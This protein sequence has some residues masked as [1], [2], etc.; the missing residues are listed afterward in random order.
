MNPF[1]MSDNPYFSMFPLFY[2]IKTWSGCYLEI[3]YCQK[4]KIGQTK[5]LDDITDVQCDLLQVRSLYVDQWRSR[6]GPQSESGADS[7]EAERELTS[8]DAAVSGVRAR[9][10]LASLLVNKL[11][12]ERYCNGY[13]APRSLFCERHNRKVFC[14]TA[15]A[16]CW[17][18]FFS[19]PFFPHISQCHI[20]KPINDILSPRFKGE[21]S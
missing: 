1:W 20:A 4:N 17:I 19:L 9:R 10:R 3:S 7:P 18:I 8:G 15:K 11:K 16:I 21:N 13:H 6:R 14:E 2:Y 5:H 12:T